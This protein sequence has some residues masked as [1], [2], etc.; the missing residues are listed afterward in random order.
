MLHGILADVLRH[1]G[2]AQQR[3]D[4]TLVT[5]RR[6]PLDEPIPDDPPTVRRKFVIDPDE[7]TDMG[8]T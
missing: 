5:I 4:I 7:N 8:R 2:K 3:D 6:T 1:K